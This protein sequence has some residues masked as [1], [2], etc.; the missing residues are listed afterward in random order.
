MDTDTPTLG[1]NVTNPDGTGISVKVADL[2]LGQGGMAALSFDPTTGAVAVENNDSGSNTYE[3]AVVRT[4]ADGSQNTFSGTLSDGD[5]V[6]AVI[7]VGSSWDGNS[8]P[9]TE[10]IQTPTLPQL[11]TTLYLPI[12]GKMHGAP[13]LVVESFT[14]T[15][16]NAQITIRNVGNSAVTEAFWVE[17]YIAPTTAP[18]TVNQL[19]T[20]LSTQGMV[21]GVTESILPIA[22]GERIILQLQDSFYSPPYSHLAGAL[23]VGTPVYVQVD[24]YNEATTYGAVLETDEMTGGLY[25]NIASTTVAA[26][27]VREEPL[28]SDRTIEAIPSSSLPT[29]PLYT[30]NH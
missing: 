5:G 15:P 9:P 19:W 20:D 13:D 14:V 6:G 28:S 3:V 8:P 25:N 23:A 11:S 22:P 4:N 12:I 30:Q 1:I 29:R 17:A 21:W 10:T 26:A 24:S 27:T 18:T 2:Q 16:D 7:N